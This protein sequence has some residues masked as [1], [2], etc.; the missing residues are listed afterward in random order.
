M[1]KR[2]DPAWDRL[3]ADIEAV[4]FSRY[5]ENREPW[6][7]RPPS[8]ANPI[9]FERLVFGNRLELLWDAPFWAYYEQMGMTN[10]QRCIVLDNVLSERGQ[11]RWLEGAFEP[12]K[13][14]D[15]VQTMMEL[16]G[17]IRWYMTI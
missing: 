7:G 1:L 9:E 8:G 4:V 2:E 6:L 13:F 3:V 15:R 14:R 12:E 5:V 11:D 16:K 10:E 17:L